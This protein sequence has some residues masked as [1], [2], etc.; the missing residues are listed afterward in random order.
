MPKIVRLEPG[1]D[2]TAQINKLPNYSQAG[3][4]IVIGGILLAVA[5]FWNSAGQRAA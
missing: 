3:R 5:R 2:P 1:V 4:L